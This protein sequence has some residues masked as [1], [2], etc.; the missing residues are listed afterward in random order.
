MLFGMLLLHA[1]RAARFDT[2][3]GRI[4]AGAGFA[5]VAVHLFGVGDAVALGAKVGA[6]QWFCAGLVLAAARVIPE[7]GLQRVD[8]VAV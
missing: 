4:A 6:F 7:P 8:D 2:V 1:N 3:A 5:L